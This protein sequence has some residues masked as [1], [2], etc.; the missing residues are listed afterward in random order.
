M[1]FENQNFPSVPVFSATVTIIPGPPP[2]PEPQQWPIARLVDV[3]PVNLL[4]QE[5]VSQAAGIFRRFGFGPHEFLLIDRLD[6]KDTLNWTTSIKP[7]DFTGLASYYLAEESG[8]ARA[9]ISV[10]G[11]IDEVGAELGLSMARMAGESFD[12]NCDFF[13]IDNDD[14]SIA[15]QV[16]PGVRGHAP[17]VMFGVSAAKLK[18]ELVLPL[19]IRTGTGELV[20]HALGIRPDALPAKL[21]EIMSADAGKTTR[22]KEITSGET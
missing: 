18:I 3:T 10:N 20:A 17:T 13:R 2:P 11:V 8:E 19:I 7:S 1:G 14:I 12:V 21:A 4:D 6:G 22:L 9:C 5:D 15:Y 16:L